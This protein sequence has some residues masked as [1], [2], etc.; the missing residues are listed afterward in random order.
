MQGF[1]GVG[2]G[3]PGLGFREL[4]L[5]GVCGFVAGLW[6]SAVAGGLYCLFVYPC[7]VCVVVSL[8]RAM[9]S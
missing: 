7:I 4:L 1:R 2:F 3:I 5:Y 6:V 8:F 9:C